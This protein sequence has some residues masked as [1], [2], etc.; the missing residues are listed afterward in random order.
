M[1]LDAKPAPMPIVVGAPRSGTTLLRLMLDAH[2][3]IA[4]P[5]ETG[6][7]ALAEPW[8]DSPPSAEAFV[9]AITNYPP[10]APTWPD[11]G[12]DRGAFRDALRREAPPTP[13]DAVRFF[14]RTYAAR[15]GKRRFGDKTPIHCFSLPAIVR[16]LP[17]ARVIHVV[18]DGRAVAASWRRTWFAPGPTMTDLAAAWRRHVEAVRTAVSAHGVRVL[19]VPYEALVT[20]PARMLRTVCAWIDLRFDASMLHY[21]ESAAARLVEHGDRVRRDGT[22]VATH[23]QR[24]AQQ[25][26]VRRPPARE[27]IDAWRR[28]LSPAEIAEFERDAG[29][30]LEDVGY[31]RRSA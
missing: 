3:E 27:R 16:L 14:Y 29:T 5:P 18:R 12:I 17:E 20:D 31:A 1:R 26:G 6:F 8:L 25:A 15:F 24:L 11:F 23:A 13:A 10:D 28:D 22:V 30:L 9:D 7:L 21:H 2:P 4:I 19:D